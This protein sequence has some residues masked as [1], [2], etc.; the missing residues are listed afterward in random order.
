MIATNSITCAALAI[1]AKSFTRKAA[2]PVFLFLSVA[3]LAGCG[4]GGFNIVL[5][6][7]ANPPVQQS[8]TPTPPPVQQSTTPTRAYPAQTPPA[9]T[10]PV[11]NAKSG[12]SGFMWGKSSPP[13]PVTPPPR[14][15]ATGSPTPTG[16]SVVRAEMNTAIRH[17]KSAG[18]TKT[19]DQ[20]GNLAQGGYFD[21]KI[22]SVAPGQELNVGALCDSGCGAIKLE[23]FDARNSLLDTKSGR[24]PLIVDTPSYPQPYTA[25]VTMSR[26]FKPSCNWGLIAATRYV[27]TA[28]A[29]APTYTAPAPTYTAPAPAPTPSYSGADDVRSRMKNAIGVV[30]AAGGAL[31]HQ[32]QGALALNRHVDVK[33]SKVAAGQELGIGVVCDNYCGDMK[34]ELYNAASQLVHTA[35]GITANADVIN[36][37]PQNYTARITMNNCRQRTCN[38][39]LVAATG[40]SAVAPVYTPSPVAPVAPVAASGGQGPITALH[41]GKC[42]AIEGAS[43]ADGARVIQRGC[44]GGRNQTF[45]GRPAGVGYLNIVA[46]HSG[47]CLDV[48]NGSTA[49]NLPIQ[50]YQCDGSDE[51]RFAFRDV[52]GGYYNLVAAHSGKCLDVPNGSTAD[53]LPIQQYQ[54]DGSPEQRFK[55]Q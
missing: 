15:P 24:N 31:K 13:P 54:C 12:G 19:R 3:V 30:Q 38:W 41:S 16:A 5:P 23:L 32:Q 14:S 33:I 27:A 28:P 18:G 29:P 53:N 2:P 47:K 39:G 8:T 26:C 1:A 17:A 6:D 11:K 50:Q 42:I 36:N 21:V 10:Y 51:Q 37:Y 55:Y 43:T 45:E 49:D 34:L 35:N 9:K 4:P 48:P 46:T 22:S 7:S 20:Q 25:R 44:S 52:G 40:P